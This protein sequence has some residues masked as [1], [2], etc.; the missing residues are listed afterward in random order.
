MLSIVTISFNNLPGII[1]TH[2]SLKSQSNL[3]FDWIVIDGGSTDGTVDFL[4]AIKIPLRYLSE[5]D[6]GIYDAML[7]GLKISKGSY[8][9]FLNAGDILSE[10][11]VID[12][13]LPRL[14]NS[15]VYFFG[16]RIRGIGTTYIRKPRSLTSASYSVPAVQQATVYRTDTLRVLD[17]PDRFRICGDYAIAAQL[18]NMSASYVSDPLVIS[19]FELG[20]VS[21]LK[22]FRLATEAYII[23][24]DFLKLSFILRIFHFSRRLLTGLSIFTIF[25]IKS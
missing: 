2:E 9:L 16:C 12:S 13:L 6:S 8:L 1:R 11:S 19:E 24:R 22:P 23:Q 7:K 21:T 17:W 25:L 20:G 3:N 14:K 15:D 10:S 4:S 18:L 5:P